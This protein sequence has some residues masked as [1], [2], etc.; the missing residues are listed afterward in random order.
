MKKLLT[1]LFSS[2]AFCWSAT[3]AG[4]DA[5]ADLQSDI[6]AQMQTANQ[7]VGTA[8]SDLKKS[9]KKRLDGLPGFEVGYCK[10]DG[11][12]CDANDPTGSD[13]EKAD[14]IISKMIG[15]WVGTGHSTNQGAQQPFIRV[16]AEPDIFNKHLC[17][18]VLFKNSSEIKFAKPFYMGKTVVLCAKSADGTGLINIDNVDVHTDDG[19]STAQVHVADGE[20]GWRCFNP[21]DNLGNQGQAF[22]Y[23]SDGTRIVENIDGVLNNCITGKSE[24]LTY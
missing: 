23:D 22:G 6:N 20:A 13:T 2:V 11:V 17:L 3:F 1:G 19:G 8:L 15:G 9:L 24:D 14:V 7:I 4:V 18:E 10:T 16:A 12:D 21:D 5:A